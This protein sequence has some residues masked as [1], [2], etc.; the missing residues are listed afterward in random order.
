MFNTNNNTNWTIGQ[1]QGLQTVYSWGL[2]AVCGYL[3]NGTTQG[4]CSNTSFARPFTPFDVLVDDTPARYR[5]PVTFFISNSDGV[6]KFIN[7][8]YLTTLTHVAFYLIFIATIATGVALFLYVKSV[9]HLCNHST[10][11]QRGFQIH[12][13]VCPVN[14]ACCH[15]GYL[16]SGL[17][18]IM[19][20]SYQARQ[21]YKRR[22]NCEYGDGGLTLSN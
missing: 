4:G 10:T 21:E 8:N 20:D 13:D 22:P 7:S 11:F 14:N 15:F 9:Y 3:I 5:T 18:N 19:V 16:Y 12:S 17:F 6:D 1:G 2:Y